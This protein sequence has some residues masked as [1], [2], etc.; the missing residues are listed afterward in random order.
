M[1]P[2]GTPLT[3]WLARPTRC[4]NTEMERGE[5]SWQTS[6]TSPMSMPSSSE[7]VATITLS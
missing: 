5:P 7:A 2:L 1:R 4:R 3:E 6:S